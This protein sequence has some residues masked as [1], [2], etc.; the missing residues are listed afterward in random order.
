MLSAIKH[1]E[2]GQVF[3]KLVLGLHYVQVGAEV[4]RKLFDD[5]SFL[6]L[7]QQAVVDQDAGELRSDGLIDECGG[8]RRIDTAR[9]AANHAVVAD[10][11]ADVVDGL[12]GEIAQTP[13]VAATTDL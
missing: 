2:P 8:D 3:E 11:S 6:G 4:V 5:G 1:D 7:A 12:P 9:E 13:G 10:A